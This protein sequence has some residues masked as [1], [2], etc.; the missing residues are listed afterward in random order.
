MQAPV[1]VLN[2]NQQRETGRK[3]QLGN[4]QAAKSVADIIRSTL[5]PR[6]ML[7]MLLDPM[8]IVMTNDGNSI[9]RNVNVSHPAAK[10][11]IELSRTQDE[12]VGDGTTS[13]LILAGEMLT[14]ATD[15]FERNIHPTLICKGYMKALEDA[16]SIM[17]EIAVSVDQEDSALVAQIVDSAVGTKFSGRYGALFRDLAIKAVRMVADPQP[18]GTVDIDIKRYARIEKIPGGD[19]EDSHVLNGVMIN[20]Y[21]LHHDMARRVENPR[22]LLMDCPMEYKKGESQTDVELTKE[23]DYK[24]M[25]DMEQD[26]IKLMCDNIIAVKPDIVITEKGCSDL[27]IHYMLKAGIVTMRRLRKTDN[28][29]IAKVTGATIVNSTDEIQESDVGTKCKLFYSEKITSEEWYSFFVEC[30]DPK[31]CT[32]IVRGGTKDTQQ[33]I[34][35]NLHDAM[36]VA[37]NIVAS[38]SLL[39]GGGATEMAVAQGLRERGKAISGVMQVPYLAVADAL[40]VIPRTLAENCGATVIRLITQLRAKHANREGSTWGI[41][42]NLGTLA[43]MEQLGIWEPALV[44]SQSIKTAIESACLLLRIDDI[45]SG[46]AHKGGE[47][48][49]GAPDGAPQQEEGHQN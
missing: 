21:P 31:A 39:P 23:E 9:I 36:Q 3:A 7:K 13:V 8:G 18:D 1:M 46:I 45:H 12:E 48:Q 44:K 35:H 10:S 34:W 49:G 43:D 27:A 2:T 4:I 41:D 37:K 16:E 19:L 6:A 33:E 5:G 14:N 29:R 24:K 26:A 47:K 28:N 40:E 38:P 32:I 20:K 17:N 42:G 11:M 15:F 25:L 30:E 22:V